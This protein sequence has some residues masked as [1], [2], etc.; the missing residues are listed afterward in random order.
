MKNILWVTLLLVLTFALITCDNGNDESTP[1]VGGITVTKESGVT[2][3]QFNTA[4]ANINTAYGYLGNL[5]KDSFAVKVKA[6]HVVTGNGV[7]LEGTTLK[8]GIGADGNVIGEYVIF[9]VLA[10]IQPSHRIRLT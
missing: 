8:V 7:I 10:Q 5:E 4:V 1:T 6:I 9:T 2:T 3:Q